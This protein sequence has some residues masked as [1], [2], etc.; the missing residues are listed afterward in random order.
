MRTNAP[1]GLNEPVI[2]K[3]SSLAEIWVSQRRLS[4]SAGTDVFLN[5]LRSGLPGNGRVYAQVEGPF[6]YHSW[7]AA[8]RAGR[9]FV[10]NGPMLEL[11]VDGGGIGSTLRRPAPAPVRQ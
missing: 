1:R 8:V 4:A 11:K 9:T 5:K 6:T 2:C 3:F 7:A 10:T